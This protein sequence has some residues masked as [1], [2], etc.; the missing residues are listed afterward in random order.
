MI[1]LDSLQGLPTKDTRQIELEF[2][3]LHV[4]GGRKSQNPAKEFDDV[5]CF[6][7]FI[8][9]SQAKVC[10]AVSGTCRLR[11]SSFL[12]NIPCTLSY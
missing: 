3:V 8:L 6:S 11:D 1:I 2:V 9:G 10:R 12:I 7:S 5:L 4:K